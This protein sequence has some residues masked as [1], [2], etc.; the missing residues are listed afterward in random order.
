MGKKKKK[1]TKGSFK[2]FPQFNYHLR[3]YILLNTVVSTLLGLGS[4]VLIVR[5]QV[6]SVNFIEIDSL[7]LKLIFIISIGLFIMG[8]YY[9]KALLN[10]K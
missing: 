4:L 1:L 3:L 10:D 8:Y 6:L 5:K 7:I 9:N 2:K